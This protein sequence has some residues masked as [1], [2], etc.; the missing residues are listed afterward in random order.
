MST[1]GP[2]RYYLGIEIS[3]IS[4]GFFSQENYIHNLLSRSAL[5]LLLM[6]VLLRLIQLMVYLHGS[7]GE[8]LSDPTRYRHLVGS[9]VFLAIASPVI[10][11]LFHMLSESVCFYSHPGSH[12]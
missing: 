8:P 12:Q 6:S 11:Y 7:D 4:D 1:L 3:Y 5:S 10:S 9:L 2:L